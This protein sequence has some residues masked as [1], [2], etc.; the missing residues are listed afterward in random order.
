MGIAF[1][2]HLLH[3]VVAEVGNPQRARPSIQRQ[4]ERERRVA[5]LDRQINLARIWINSL[6]EDHHAVGK[7]LALKLARLFALLNLREGALDFVIDDL[8][9]LTYCG[10]AA[11]Y[12]SDGDLIAADNVALRSIDVSL[13]VQVN[14]TV[15][16]LAHMF[17]PIW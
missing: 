10:H 6:H 8:C 13:D 1:D 3:G 14:V 5:C 11:A 12:V 17:P 7:L 16:V 4:R 2:F 15:I 9:A